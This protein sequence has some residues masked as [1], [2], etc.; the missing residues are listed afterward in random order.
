MRN[1]M[2]TRD[3]YFSK[4]EA[5]RY[6][7]K[8]TRWLDYQLSGQTPPPGFKIGKRWLFKKSE[9]DRWLEQFRASADLDRLVDETVAEVLGK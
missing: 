3:Y 1:E 6:L 4:I 8:S 5:A 7:G 9:I 2:H